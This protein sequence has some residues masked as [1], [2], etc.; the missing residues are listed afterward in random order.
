MKTGEARKMVNSPHLIIIFPFYG[1][2]CG[3]DQFNLPPSHHP[4][5]SFILSF[6]MNYDDD[7]DGGPRTTYGTKIDLGSIVTFCALFSVIWI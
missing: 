5:Y 2:L 7:D 6:F 3:S 1:Q 4:S